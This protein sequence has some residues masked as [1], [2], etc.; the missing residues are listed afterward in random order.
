MFVSSLCVHFALI[1]AF[2][3]I[4]FSFWSTSLTM[5]VLVLDYPCKWH[6]FSWLNHILLCAYMTSLFIHLSVYILVTSMFQLLQML[7]QC[8]LVCGVVQS[9]LLSCKTQTVPVRHSVPILLPPPLAPTILLSVS[10]EPIAL[11]T[12]YEW[13]QTSFV[14]P[15]LPYVTE[16]NVF[17]VHPH[18][19]LCQNCLRFR[20]Y[21]IH[22]VDGPRSACPFFCRGTHGISTFIS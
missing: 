16:H 22:C 7:L 13:T 2:I 8:M 19:S 21:N 20:L 3:G 5:I 12:L 1:K 10:M 17:R 15:C 4:S 9:L 6:L 11:G 14:L 18:S